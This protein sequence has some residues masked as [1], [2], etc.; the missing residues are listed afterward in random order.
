GNFAL[1][2]FLCQFFDLAFR[3]ITPAALMIPQRPQWGQVMRTGDAM[4]TPYHIQNFRPV[5]IIVLKLP[6]FRPEAGLIRLLRR[7]IKVCFK[8]IVK[9]NTIRIPTTQAGVKRYT[10]V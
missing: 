1:P 8:R 3:I 5:D 6:S 2:E 10:A 4:I 7:K 9:E